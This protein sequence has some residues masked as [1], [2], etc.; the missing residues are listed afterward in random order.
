MAELGRRQAQALVPLLLA[1]CV[2]LLGLL[3][4]NLRNLD[5]GAEELPPPAIGE[6]TP[7][8]AV[9]QGSGAALRT[10]FVGTLVAFA[11]VMVVASV[12]LHRKGVKVWKLVSVWELLGYALAT[13]FLILALVYWEGVLGGLNAFVRWVTGTRDGGTGGTG[14][15][16]QLPVGSGYSTVVLLAAVAIVGL[17]AFVFASVFL[18]RL[19]RILVETPPDIGKSKRELARAVRTA[20]RDLQ[21]GED[22]RATVLRCY[23]SMVLLFEAHG[24]R[25]TPAQTAREF[26]ADALRA[27]GVSREGIDDL[28]SLFEEARYSTHA[29]GE[30]Q[31]DTAIE[32]LSVIRAQLEA[33][34]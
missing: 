16:P 6:Q 34:E 33:S 19:H 12:M 28:T 23:R 14:G 10:L 26:E 30:R 5:P 2:A 20:I 15:P 18:P 32:S 29:I 22:F 17:Y 1:V 13:A 21:A 4:F 27:I 7:S 24:L 8:V 9:Q 3:A 31:R 11:V 25:S